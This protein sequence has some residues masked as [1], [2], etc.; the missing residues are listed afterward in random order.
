MGMYSLGRTYAEVCV[1]VRK[2]GHVQWQR[3]Y[4]GGHRCHPVEIK[5]NLT[6][7]KK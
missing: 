7:M 4:L 5:D 1:C 3:D 6:L 2:L